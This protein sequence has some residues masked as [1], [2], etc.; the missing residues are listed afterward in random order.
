MKKEIDTKLVQ[1]LQNQTSE[2]KKEILNLQNSLV[3][4]QR[5]I[6]N[7]QE[8]NEKLKLQVRFDSTGCLRKAMLKK[9]CEFLT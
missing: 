2:N 7:L 8:E 4:S 5:Q 1:E 3:A 9:M 6:K